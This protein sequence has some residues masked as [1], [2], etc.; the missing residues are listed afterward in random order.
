MNYAKQNCPTT[1]KNA[2]P[3]TLTFKKNLTVVQSLHR[4]RC[5]GWVHETHYGVVKAS[6]PNVTSLNRTEISS[7]RR[8]G[9]WQCISYKP[10]CWVKVRVAEKSYFTNPGALSPKHTSLAN[11]RHGSGTL[12]L[13]VRQMPICQIIAVMCPELAGKTHRTW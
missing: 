8:S 9:W 1:L 6:P 2:L 10:A 12:Q 5:I 3:C 11:G 4:G 7:L 13:S